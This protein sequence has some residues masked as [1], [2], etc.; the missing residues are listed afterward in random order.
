K[1]ILFRRSCTDRKYRRNYFLCR[2]P[3]FG[4]DTLEKGL[5]FGNSV[6]TFLGFRFALDFLPQFL[7]FFFRIPEHGCAHTVLALLAD[8]DIVVDT[9]LAAFPKFFIWGELRIGNRLIF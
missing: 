4:L 2:P 9:A 8:E 6:Q 5:L 7:F 1:L 3:Q